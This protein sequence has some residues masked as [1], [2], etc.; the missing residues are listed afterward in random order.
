MNRWLARSVF[1][2]GF[3]SVSAVFLAA[4]LESSVLVWLSVAGLGVFVVL[5]ALS[6]FT[7][8]HLVPTIDEV[9]GRGNGS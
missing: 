6:V 3:G 4:I 9:F 1:G 5:V 2:L 8:L 7:S